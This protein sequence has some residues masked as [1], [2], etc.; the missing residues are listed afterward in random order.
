MTAAAE[1]GVV[2]A[3]RIGLSLAAALEASG[4]FGGVW[5]AGRRPGRPDF[6]EGRDE[7]AY[8]P[9]EDRIR[10]LSR[11]SD[12][13]LLLFFCVPDG[14]IREAARSWGRGLAEAGLL[15]A[16]GAATPSGPA[17]RAAFHTSGTRPASEL[18]PLGEATDG[19]RPPVASFHPLCAVARP[20]ADA[21]RGVTFG[22]EGEGEAAELAEEL[23]STIGRRALRVRP[24][25]KARYHAGA[26]LASN[27]LVACLGAG[28]GQVRE[29]SGGAASADD[30]LPLARS[31]LDQVERHGPAAGLTGPVVR[32]DL[33]TVR[34]HLEALDPA[35]RSLYASLTE[36]L[37]RQ[38]DVEP[39]VRRAVGEM[40]SGDGGSSA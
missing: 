7:I 12:G 19:E 6:L 25:E 15:P 26:V 39:A 23:A 13:E 20:E 36:E 4:D 17:L 2:G 29:A 33:E 9:R 1:A 18:A 28:L 38:A 32:G 5:V 34:S 27:L 40:V 21:F 10:E 16:T 35:A 3:G 24:G 8:G 30:L 37:L 31:A 11:R 14:S 22:V